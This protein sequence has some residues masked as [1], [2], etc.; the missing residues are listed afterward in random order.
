M[1]HTLV[2]HTC[3]TPTHTHTCATPSC[4]QD[5]IDKPITAHILAY[6]LPWMAPITGVVGKTPHK[7]KGE[8]LTHAQYAVLREVAAAEFEVW[9]YAKERYELQR[10]FLISLGRYKR[11]TPCETGWDME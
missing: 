6:W 9:E 5:D 7:P 11:V 3:D 2:C 8:A 4:A 10:R 1:C